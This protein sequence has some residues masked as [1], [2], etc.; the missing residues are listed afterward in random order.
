MKKILL[1]LLLIIPFIG[2]GQVWEHIYGDGNEYGYSIKQTLDGGYIISGR[3]SD[4]GIKLIKIDV[5]GIKIWEKN[6]GPLYVESYVQQTTDGGYIV[7][8][9]NSL[10]KTN[11]NGDTLWTKTRSSICNLYSVQQTSDGGYIVC[12]EVDILNNSSSKILLFKTNVNGDQQWVKN[13]GGDDIDIGTSVKQTS[14]GGFIITG[15]TKSFGGVFNNESEIYLLKTDELGDSLW[16]KTYP[17]P[18]GYDYGDGNSVKQTNDGGYVI[19]GTIGGSHKI[20]LIKTNSIGDTSWTSTLGGNNDD[21]GNDIQQT[22]DGGYIVCGRSTS[23]QFG[24][25]G[26]CLIKIDV[27][28]NKIWSKTFKYLNNDVNE[29][30]SIQQTIDGGYI[31]CGTT[32]NED[33]LGY[34]ISVI[35]VIKT[36]SQGNI[37]STFNIPTQ[38][39]KRKLEKI[40]DIL[41]RE[42]KPQ[43]NTPFVEIYDDGSTDKKLIIEK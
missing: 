8:G 18:N 43:T 26:V 33:N 34:I 4:S 17:V 16:L 31:I 12:G 10:I 9:G 42:T 36:D 1:T 28:G 19:C 41:G 15:S 40:V 14:D 13:F 32:Q 22:L 6:Y 11:N 2:V 39:S 38:S 21:Y 35:Y 25:P 30:N 23:N 7:C 37:T 24:N 20:R 27:Y 3:E 29:G 5:N